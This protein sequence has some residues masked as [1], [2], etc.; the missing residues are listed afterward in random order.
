MNIVAKLIA[1]LDATSGTM[2]LFCI[3]SLILSV[4]LTKK[5]KTISA[6]TAKVSYLSKIIQDLDHQA[7]LIIK[8]DMEAKLY[9][10]EVEEE[11]NKLTLIKSLI[12]S[13][14]HILDRER[15]FLQID[16]KIINQLG[17]E[18]GLIL[19]FDALEVKVNFGF[20][21]GNI[22]AIRNMLKYKKQ[23]LKDAQML[24]PDSEIYSQISSELQL[25]ELLIVPI[26][27]SE[28][29][30][31]IFIVANHMFH[32]EIKKPEKEALLIICMYLSRCLD[33]IR[34]FEDYYHVRDNLEKKIKERTNELVK[35]LR[36]IEKISKV[37]SD[38]I[39]SV[40]HELRTPLTSVKGFSSL[41]VG[42]KF[43]KLPEEAKARLTKIDENVNK[44]MDIVNTLLDI[45]RI[46]SRRME[47][48]IVPVE[49][50]KVIKDVTDF[51]SPQTESKKIK[52]TLDAPQA[53]NVYADKNLI[54]RVFI[55]LINNAIKFTPQEGKITV[56]CEKKDNWALFTVADNGCGIGQEDLGKIFQE[57]F[58]ASSP[59]G[60]EV[61]GS[62]LGL[63]L[64][65]RIIDTHKEKIWVESELDKGTKFYF[66]LRTVENV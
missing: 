39:S 11:M 16:E 24:P 56:S 54:E 64:V 31:A 23:A 49:I 4:L 36:E 45:S 2:I 65:K 66:T 30:Y 43:G 20:S 28:H 12:I 1:S 35:S 59:L 42:E 37:K 38:F 57:F 25:K 33:N 55:N 52:L 48:K 10:Q 26:K 22:G 53:L 14:L 46:E 61:K 40:S 27:T 13:S 60:S 8:S 62:G 50:V 34:L 18:K 58:R 15:L 51:L 44:L 9:Q 29:I 17:F 41:L 32:A 63:S 6:L 21:L 19:S 47:I 5:M 7:K 3:V